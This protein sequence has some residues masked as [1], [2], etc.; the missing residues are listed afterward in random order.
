[1]SIRTY[2]G[3]LLLQNLF[4]Y[5]P[6]TNMGLY[7]LAQGI[8]YPSV[9]VTVLDCG[10]TLGKIETV[11]FEAEGLTQLS[12]DEVLS[13]TSIT[14]LLSEGI[15]ST[16]TRHVSTCIAPGGCCTLCYQ[17][18]Y[19]QDVFPTV[20]T[21]VTIRPE[22]LVN[23]ELIQ[24]KVGA[25]SYTTVTPVGTYVKYYVYANGTLLIEGTDYTLNGNNL[26]LLVNPIT[27]FNVV[28]RFT[29]Y[30]LSPFMLWLAETYSGS[31]LGLE[32]LPYSLLPIRSLYL[33]STLSKNR[34]QLVNQQVSQIKAVPTEFANYIPKITDSLEQALYM[35][36]LY[37][38]YSNVIS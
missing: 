35:I 32:P 13:E 34:L 15:Y 1:M 28:L 23:A 19:P 5:V 11:N 6:Q 14:E 22:Y 24:A 21:R 30:D 38:I 17:A 4:N 27:N 10:T 9:P 12:N 8:F 3:T 7:N 18:T 25:T 37:S 2:A 36:A 20:N 16:A 26:T 29:T 33:T 31:I